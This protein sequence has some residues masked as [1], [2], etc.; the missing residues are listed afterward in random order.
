MT[1]CQA[2]QTLKTQSQTIRGVRILYS[3]QE[4]FLQDIVID[5]T[6]DGIR[7]KFDANCQ[8]LKIIE[9]YDL[10]KVKLRYGYPLSKTTFRVVCDCVVVAAVGHI[11]TF[12]K[13]FLPPIER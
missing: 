10:T 1:V 8:R 3:E 6:N 5:L 4:P 9:V 7:F 2:V 12:L 13:T 11:S